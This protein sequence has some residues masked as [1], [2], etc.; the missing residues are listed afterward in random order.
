M[1][2]EVLF[3]E[4]LFKGSNLW[5]WLFRW[6]FH[7]ALLLVLLRHLRYFQ[8]PVGRPSA[9]QFSAPTPASRWSP[10]WRAVGAAD[11]SSTAVRYIST[12]SDHLHLALLLAIAAHWG[13][14]CASCATP[15]S[16]PSRPS[17]S[18]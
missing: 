15:T 5:T 4:S 7:A 18:A 12:P 13:W 10:A 2:R 6:M 17:C 14:R 11:A 8:E 1:T 16:S 9:V 3:F